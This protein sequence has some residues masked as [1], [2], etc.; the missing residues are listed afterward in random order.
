MIKNIMGL[1][2]TVVIL[3]ACTT[4]CGPAP[5]LRIITEDNPPFN[6]TDERGNITGQSTEIV[7]LILKATGT[8]ASIELLPW[9][10]GY[11]LAQMEPTVA[12]YS[13]MRLPSRENL[14][15]WVGPI[16]FDDSYFYVRR[17]TLNRL[18]MPG[19]SSP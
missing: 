16:G 14:F 2:L 9:A 17:G 13:T 6:F 10:Q 12:L 5:K 4:A 11:S 3:L 7:R 8:D 18:T 19:N 1:I 15:K